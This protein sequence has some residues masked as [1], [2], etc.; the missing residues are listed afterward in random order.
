M[1]RP[2]PLIARVTFAVH[3]IVAIVV[4]FPLLIAPA[5]ATSWLGY[6][7]IPDYVQPAL[8]AF[9]AMILA[10]GGLTSFYGLFSPTWERVSYIV[11][12]EI[13]Y[14]AIQTGIFIIAGIAGTGPA[15]A[16]WVFALVSF[17]LLVLFV[18]SFVEQRTGIRALFGNRAS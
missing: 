8:R 4:G 2:I 7:S 14:L 17:I 10:F 6:G 16:N 13:A 1:D 5:T 3:L 15:L 12:G 9:G 18:A 11:R